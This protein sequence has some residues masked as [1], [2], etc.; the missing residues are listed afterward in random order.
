MLITKGTNYPIGIDFSDF[1]IKFAQLYKKGD[2]IGVQA[3]GKIDL[4]KTV[5]DNGEIKDMNTAT[6]AVKKMLEKPKYGF[7]IGHDV[8]ASLPE[9]KAFVKLVYIDKGPNK[10]DAIIENEIEKYIPIAVKDMIFDWQIISETAEKY[11]V[12]I[13]AAPK[14]IVNQYIQ[15][16]HN[17][18]LAVSGLEIE[19]IPIS[20]CLLVEESPKFNNKF[21]NNYGIIDI[22][23]KRTNMT[24]YSVNTVCLSISMPI[25]GDEITE[26][27]AETLEISKEQAEKA[28]II[29]GLDKKVADGVVSSILEGMVNDLLDR[30][31]EFIEFYRAHYPDYGNLNKI[32]LCGGGAN[33]KDLTSIIKNGTGIETE[34]GDPFKNITIIPDKLLQ[35]FE[36][37]HDISLRLAKNAE[38]HNSSIK[39]SAA[40]TYT[41]AIGLALRNIF[42]NKL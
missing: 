3:L 13:G 19:S 16:L 15:L 36:E 18:G 10:L 29:C 42:L 4:P 41:S 40:L 21:S 25:S 24:I 9:I 5:F 22:G 7:L 1:N 26:K 32:L 20:R 23:A 17:A 8:V 2:K 33:I 28:K 35:I 31:N 27:I 30:I 34:A 39:Q 38:T 11:S 37:K 12:L 6:E 14:T